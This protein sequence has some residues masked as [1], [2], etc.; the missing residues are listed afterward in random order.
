MFLRSSAIIENLVSSENTISTFLCDTGYSFIYISCTLGFLLSSSYSIYMSKPP[1]TSLLKKK[2]L[3]LMLSKNTNH[4]PP[5]LFSYTKTFVHKTSFPIKLIRLSIWLRVF[6]FIPFTKHIV[7]PQNLLNEE[8]KSRYGPGGKLS[9]GLIFG[10]NF[11]QF[12]R[13]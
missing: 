5:L 13:H 9:P 8:M 3:L 12:T 4:Y 2:N 10:L 6:T 7:N 11:P 1:V